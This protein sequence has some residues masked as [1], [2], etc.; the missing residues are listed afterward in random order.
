MG[1]RKLRSGAE[2]S[3]ALDQ[4]VVKKQVLCISYIPHNHIVM[5]QYSRTEQNYSPKV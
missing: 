3:G 5:Q 4:K 1:D 2:V